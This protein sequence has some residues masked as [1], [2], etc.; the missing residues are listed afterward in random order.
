MGLTRQQHRYNERQ[1]A[2]AARHGNRKG[3]AAAQISKP[4]LT[5]TKVISGILASLCGIGVAIYNFLPS[6]DVI[7]QPWDSSTGPANARFQ[8][9]NIS[10]A[11]IR[12]VRFDCLINNQTNKDFGTSGNSSRQPVIGEK[13]QVIGD[14]APDRFVS[15]DCFGGIS[16]ELGPHPSNIRIDASFRWPVIN[17]RQDISRYFVSET[18]GRRWWMTPEKEPKT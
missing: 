3:R 14:L 15:R 4:F 17:F 8:F 1:A 7:A 9:K 13:S 6:L 10:R 11:T 5:R 18:D 2:K 12:D 16:A